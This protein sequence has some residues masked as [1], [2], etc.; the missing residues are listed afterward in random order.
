M[1]KIAIIPLI[2]I[3]KDQDVQNIEIDPEIGALVVG[4]FDGNGEGNGNGDRKT[5]KGSKSTSLAIHVL[6]DDVREL[7]SSVFKKMFD[8]NS[9]NNNK[10]EISPNGLSPRE[11]EVLRLIAQGNTNKEIA[12]M[13]FLSVKTIETH[14]RNIYRKL[15]IHNRTHATA[16]AIRQGLV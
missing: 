7:L 16:Y 10:K 6:Q 13:L 5:E 3:D 2:L 11:T 4:I 15:K 9:K 8:Q 14:R 1:K 12:K